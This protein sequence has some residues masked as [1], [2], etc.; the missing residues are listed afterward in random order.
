M[1]AQTKGL[2]SL[3]SVTIRIYFQVETTKGSKMV[4]AEVFIS[5]VCASVSHNILELVSLLQLFEVV[6]PAPLSCIQKERGLQV[7]P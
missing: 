1:S 7:S 6:T 3:C 5:K 4:F 2:D